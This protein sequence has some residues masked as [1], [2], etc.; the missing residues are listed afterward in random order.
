MSY[1]RRWLEDSGSEDSH[2]RTL[3]ALGTL[4]RRGK[5]DSKR[6]LAAQLFEAALPVVSEFT[7][8]R[9]WAFA[10]IGVNEYLYRYP[11]HRSAAP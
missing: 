1:D 4:T 10:L 6:E 8:P 5:N 2:G 9:A 3:W 11:E 7:S